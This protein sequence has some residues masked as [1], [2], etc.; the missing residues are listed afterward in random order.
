MLP[1]FQRQ[2]RWLLT[3]KLAEISS[4]Q[5]LLQSGIKQQQHPT[6]LTAP[7]PGKASCGDSTT[8]RNDCWHQ[9]PSWPLFP[10]WILGTSTLPQAISPN[11]SSICAEHSSPPRHHSIS[12]HVRAGKRRQQVRDPSDYAFHRSA[13]IFPPSQLCVEKFTNCIYFPGH[14]MLLLLL[15]YFISC[16]RAKWNCT[17]WLDQLACKEKV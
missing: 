14:E 6:A 10:T 16:P 17:Q 2:N 11:H 13:R 3:V 7:A 8:L 4:S 15:A 1:K 12:F 5:L 9:T